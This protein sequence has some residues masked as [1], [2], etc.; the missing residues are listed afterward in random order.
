VRIRVRGEDGWRRL[1]ANVIEL[2]THSR[3]MWHDKDELMA[4][5]S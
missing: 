2:M 1:S 5:A 4:E 3:V